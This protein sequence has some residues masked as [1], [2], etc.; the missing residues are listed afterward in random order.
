[1]AQKILSNLTTEWVAITDLIIPEDGK[2]YSIQNRGPDMVIAQESASKPT[3]KAG[4]CIP[5]YKVLKYVKGT[6]ILYLKS[7]GVSEINISDED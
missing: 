3:D 1:M 6:N 7:Y 4:I 2:N 5:S